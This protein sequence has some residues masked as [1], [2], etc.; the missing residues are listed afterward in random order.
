MRSGYSAD[1]YSYLFGSLLALR[2]SDPWL[3]GMA[4][5][6][7]LA[8]W[9]L[10]GRWAYATFDR[11]LARADR[12]LPER[13]DYMLAASIALVIVVAIKLVGMVLIAAF[14]VIP[15]AAAR[16]VA[17][18]FV[19]MTALACAIG[20]LSAVAGLLLAYILD[21][22]TGSVIILLQT[23]LFATALSIRGQRRGIVVD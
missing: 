9:P 8:L 2:P 15:A 1:A 7:S 22:P 21:M 5:V 13:D 14:L 12:V 10:W 20:A 16:L 23:V 19:A 6:G 4:C 17:R 3:A 11:E 18:T